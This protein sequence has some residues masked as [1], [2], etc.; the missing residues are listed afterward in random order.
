[1]DRTAIVAAKRIPVLRIGK[2]WGGYSSM[3]LGARVI[4]A[5]LRILRNVSKAIAA[6]MEPEQVIMGNFSNPREC[7]N[8][9]KDAC[10]YAGFGINHLN[11]F[12][13]NKVCSSG[14]LSVILGDVFIRSGEAKLV[15]TGGMENLLALPKDAMMALLRD[16]N[17]GEMTW[18]AGEWCAKNFGISRE[19]QD[20]WAIESYRRSSEAQ[21]RGVFKEEIVPFE[22]QE[23]DEEPLRKLDAN[24]IRAA[25][26]IPRC[27]TI[28][29]LNSSKNAGCAAAVMLASEKTCKKFSLQPLA[30]IVSSA[31][32]GLGGDQKR[33]T[34]APPCAIRKASA[35]GGLRLISDI[36]LYF[37][38][39]AFSSVTLYAQKE[40]G[41]PMERLNI[42]G[43]AVSVGHP[44]GATGAKLLV[45][46]VHAL[47]NLDKRYAVVSLCNAPAEATAMIIE[48]A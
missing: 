6:G 12:T 25:E 28:T 20:N 15:I 37:I 44:I 33:F 1:M 23:L 18:D 38:N 17:T 46:A 36:D 8:P 22:G 3:R 48:R 7:L 47:R 41:I 14:L 4:D 27:S 34:I 2:K 39:T 45:E 30:Y 10:V 13:V 42:N 21:E 29:P 11:A 26:T 19:E 31:S 43:D 24:A 32:V 5:L 40:L 9:A 16:P 35:R